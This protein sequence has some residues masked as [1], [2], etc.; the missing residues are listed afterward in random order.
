MVVIFSVESCKI[1]RDKDDN[2]FYGQTNIESI[3]TAPNHTLGVHLISTDYTWSISNF[4]YSCLGWVDLLY[5][6]PLKATPCH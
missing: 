1:K 5:P 2:F 6:V 4:R 3:Q